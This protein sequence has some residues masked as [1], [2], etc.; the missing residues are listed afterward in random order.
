[1][2]QVEQWFSVLQRKR[3]VALNFADLTDFESKILKFISEWNATAHPL[4]W[5]LR[6]FAKIDAAL[7]KAV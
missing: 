4:D 2:N 5:A 1:M 7:P 3:N 6:S